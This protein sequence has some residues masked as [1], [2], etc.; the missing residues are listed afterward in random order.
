M[1]EPPTSTDPLFVKMKAIEAR[2]IERLKQRRVQESPSFPPEAPETAIP[3]PTRGTTT[4][5]SFWGHKPVALMQVQKN[6][7][8]SGTDP[9]C[10]Q[11]TRWV[12]F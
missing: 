9:Y 3:Q 5:P 1:P 4:I 12:L 7:R 10:S 8:F 6:E 11:Q 2:A